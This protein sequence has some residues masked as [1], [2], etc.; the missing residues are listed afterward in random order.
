MRMSF[1]YLAI[2]AVLSVLGI[3]SAQA[4]LVTETWQST[5]TSANNAAFAAGDTFTWTVTYDDA[6]L[7]MHTYFDSTNGI[8]EFGA[9][10]DTLQNTL[11]TG[12]EAYTT[13]CGSNYISSSAGVAGHDMFSDAQYDLSSFEAYM[14]TAGKA[15][16]DVYGANHAWAYTYTDGTG[17]S[18]NLYSVTADDIY[19]GGVSPGYT[20]SAS[21]YYQDPQYTYPISL[22]VSFTSALISTTSAAVPEPTTLALLG[23]GLVGL[24]VSRKRKLKT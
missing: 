20:G 8:A 12:S 22:D 7:R 16:T 3:G 5:V 18:R 6:S 2:G 15:G 17:S 13:G 9:G 1:Q 4:T 24:G 10:D 14:D 21:M 19:F 11:C 23:I